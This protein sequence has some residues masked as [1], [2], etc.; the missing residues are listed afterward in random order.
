MKQLPMKSGEA[1]P[2]TLV[3]GGRGA[4]RKSL[5][6]ASWPM[7]T[8]R[9][10]A[11]I[12]L[13]AALAAGAQAQATWSV[14]DAP[15]LRLLHEHGVA[16][17]A[18]W[19]ENLQLGALSLGRCAASLVSASGLA[20][21]SL[22]CMRSLLKDISESAFLART[23]EEEY[24]V[25]GAE[26]FQL[27]GIYDESAY[28][29]SVAGQ[30]TVVEYVSTGFRSRALV[31]RRY[32]DI[33]MVFAPERS[34]A[35]FGSDGTYPG[36]SLDIAFFRIYDANGEPLESE[37]YFGWT[38]RRPGAEQSVF[39]AGSPLSVSDGKVA[40][41]P[42]NGT[43]APPYTTF[44]GLYDLHY[45]HGADALWKLPRTWTASK[46]S[47]DLSVTVNFV[48][49]AA[50]SNAG[51]AVLDKDLEVLGIAVGQRD[52]AEAGDGQDVRRCV[53]VS[54]AGVVEALRSVYGAQGILAELEEQQLPGI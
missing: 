41:F 50:C 17:D 31:F 37:T 18:M 26:A 29:G 27:I 16:A 44:Y 24:A 9:S 54:A 33:R 25:P 46:A 7:N 10:L 21:T 22:G 6:T 4:F 5:I 49:A 48:A 2:C 51:A 3:A 11:V 47:L 19:L 14:D 32:R 8:Y 30:D 20:A 39:V 43:V 12:W 38:D 45:A 42:Y 23:R 53:A 35:F 36:Y 1:A 15:Y 13:F 52:I 40:G 28:R 34:I